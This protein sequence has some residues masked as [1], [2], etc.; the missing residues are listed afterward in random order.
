MDAFEV[1]TQ[2][3]D[4]IYK[5]GQGY[6]EYPNDNL[7]MITHHLFKDAHG[8]KL[9]DLGFGSGNNLV[10]LAKKGFE[11]YG[12]EISLVSLKLAKKRL[13]A[14]GLSPTLSLFN[15]GLPYPD[16]FF[17]VIVSWQ[18]LYYNSLENLKAIISDIFRVLKKEGRIVVTLVRDNDVIIKSCDKIGSMTYR[19][20]S[21]FFLQ[22]GAVLCV[23]ETEYA[24]RGLFS[25]FSRVEVGYFESNYLGRTSSHWVIIGEK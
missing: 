9:L 24:V 23:I 19:V 21:G 13:E 22:R 10:H 25:N 1:N 12:C 4:R 15:D 14:L 6:L 18:T 20:N 17:D 7:V 3:W 8:K 16:E 11:C 5:A 2:V